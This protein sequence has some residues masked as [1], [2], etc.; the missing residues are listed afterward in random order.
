[1]FDLVLVLSHNSDIAPDI[2]ERLRYRN[3][4]GNRLANSM[5][6]NAKH[7]ICTEQGVT[8]IAL[9][10][11]Y[12]NLDE[13]GLDELRSVMLGVSED[14]DPPLLVLDL[15]HTKFF[16]SAFIEILF[17][18]WNRMKSQEGGRFGISGLTE[19]CCEILEVTH[20]DQLWEIYETREDAVRALK[21]S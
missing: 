9:G 11:E 16:G 20:L 19:Y 10:M 8:V 12:E 7:E 6:S 3:R 15:S 18:I 2:S 21:S 17:R 14:A 5:S 1:L 4:E 13:K